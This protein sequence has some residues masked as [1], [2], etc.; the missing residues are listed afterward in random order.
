LLRRACSARS[1]AIRCRAFS[2]FLL[3]FDTPRTLSLAL[4]AGIPRAG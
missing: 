4:A 1:L 2:L 3:A